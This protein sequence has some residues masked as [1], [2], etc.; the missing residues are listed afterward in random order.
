MSSA[1]AVTHLPVGDPGYE[2]SGYYIFRENDLPLV[3]VTLDPSDFA[4][5]FDDPRQDEY[6]RCTFRFRNSVTD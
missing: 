1:G 2:E 5:L 6:K 4:S 3:E